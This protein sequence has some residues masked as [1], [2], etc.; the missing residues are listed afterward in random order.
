MDIVHTIAPGATIP[1]GYFDEDNISFIEQKVAHVLSAEFSQRIVIDRGSIIRIMQHM[2]A[3]RREVVPKLNQ[4]VIMYVCNDF[5]VHQMNVN[6]SLKWEEGYAESQK[7]ID[8]T[9]GLERFDM[10]GIKTTDKPK[11]NGKGTLGGTLRFHF[12]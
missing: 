8:R 2:L 10:R 7:I 1:F 12:T 9:G 11:Y 4:R 5:R 3:M 6:R